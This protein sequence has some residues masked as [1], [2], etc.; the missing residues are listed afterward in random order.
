MVTPR[1]SAELAHVPTE[2]SGECSVCFES[3]PC[4]VARA[5]EHAHAVFCPRV[6]DGFDVCSTHL[7]PGDR[8]MHAQMSLPPE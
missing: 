1:E 8:Y 7:R 6:H 5:W 2:N 3:W 4:A